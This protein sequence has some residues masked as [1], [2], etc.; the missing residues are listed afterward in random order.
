MET[1]AE[2]TRDWSIQQVSHLSC[3]GLGLAPL[4]WCCTVP[5]LSCNW[6]QLLLWQL[7]STSHLYQMSQNIN[8]HWE[9]ISHEVLCEGGTPLWQQILNSKTTVSTEFQSLA[10]KYFPWL[11]FALQHAFPVLTHG[12]RAAAAPSARITARCH[13]INI[14][15]YLP[16]A[17]RPERGR[18]SGR[19]DGVS[20]AGWGQRSAGRVWSCGASEYCLVLY[21]SHKLIKVLWVFFLYVYQARIWRSQKC[22]WGWTVA[23]YCLSCLQELSRP[24]PF[25]MHCAPSPADSCVQLCG[26]S[27]PPPCSY[28]QAVFFSLCKSVQTVLWGPERI[29]SVARC[30]STTGTGQHIS[31]SVLGVLRGRY[32][33]PS[34]YIQKTIGGIF[35]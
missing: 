20:W 16:R 7:N 33:G 31:F 14:F 29:R 10:L 2:S 17:F 34:R 24:F 30:G 15:W 28:G 5:A 18:G 3:P 23:S 21:R 19:T 35:C 9:K 27:L 22:S 6:R 11:P 25:L 32:F 4:A 8:V 12:V 1:A 13:W 26:F